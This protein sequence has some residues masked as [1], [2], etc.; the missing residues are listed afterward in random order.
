MRPP[1]SFVFG[2]CSWLLAV[3]V[4]AATLG[5]W[6]C[7]ASP[8]LPPASSTPHPFNII[9]IKV[10]KCASSTTAGVVRHIAQTTGYAP[11]TAGLHRTISNLRSC[12]GAAAV[13]GPLRITGTRRTSRACGRRTKRLGD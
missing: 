2:R 4:M 10:P 9:Y 7:L 6:P 5:S 8:L 3:T 12:I 11:V 13:R 1:A